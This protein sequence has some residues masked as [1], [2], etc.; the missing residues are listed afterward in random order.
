MRKWLVDRRKR[1]SSRGREGRSKSVVD[2][3]RPSRAATEEV[4]THRRYRRRHLR[5]H[6]RPRRYCRRRHSC[7]QWHCCRRPAWEKK[8]NGRKWKCEKGPATSWAK[9]DESK[10][11]KRSRLGRR[12]AKGRRRRRR[13]RLSECRTNRPARKCRGAV[14]GSRPLLRTSFG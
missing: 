9:I 5:R 7:F 4:A 11:P 1:V 2:R 12:G 3:V 14:T 8:E 6:R 10:T 13:S